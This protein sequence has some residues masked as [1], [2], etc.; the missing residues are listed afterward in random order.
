MQYPYA[1]LTNMLTVDT[2]TPTGCSNPSQ[3]AYL[4]TATND[5]NSDYNGVEF[6]V[7]AKDGA[8]ACTYSLGYTYAHGL[9]NFRDNLTAGQLPQN[10]Y[11]YGAEMGNSV[12]D[13]RQPL[14]RKFPVA[15]AVRSTG[16]NS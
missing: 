15:A 14:R 7:E 10:S 11:D 13:I 6:Q 1:N 2:F 3:H 12:F 4:E 9:A 8:T 5:G 16:S